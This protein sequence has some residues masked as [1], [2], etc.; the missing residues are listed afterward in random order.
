[1]LDNQGMHKRL[2]ARAGLV[3]SIGLWSNTASQGGAPC[4]WL[5]SVSTV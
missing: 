1:M 2:Q 5:L 4:N 3:A